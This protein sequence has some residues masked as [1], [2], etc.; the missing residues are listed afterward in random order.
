M[1]KSVIYMSVISTIYYGKNPSSR[2]RFQIDR[3]HVSYLLVHV[4]N[5]R[6]LGCVNSIVLIEGVIELGL[7]VVVGLT[8]V[9]KG[10]CPCHGL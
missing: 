9:N 3:R 4:V 6:R 8:S 1:H 2:L 7:E 5:G 10:Q